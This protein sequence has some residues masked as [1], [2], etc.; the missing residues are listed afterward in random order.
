MRF[1]VLALLL[2]ATVLAVLHQA[3]VSMTQMATNFETVTN[4][5]GY[6]EPLTRDRGGASRP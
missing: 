5:A 3:Q 2:S 4:M 6:G 1:A